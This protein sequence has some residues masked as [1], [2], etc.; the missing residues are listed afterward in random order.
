M[1]RRI[2]PPR[3]L[4]PAPPPPS[5]FPHGLVS[6]CLA[7]LVLWSLLALAWG[8]WG[9]WATLGVLLGCSLLLVALV[10]GKP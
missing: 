5:R 8:L 4:P 3:A 1:V 10:N 9:P 6:G 7:S 2:N